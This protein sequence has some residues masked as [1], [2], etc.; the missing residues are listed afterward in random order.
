MLSVPAT[1]NLWNWRRARASYTP[2]SDPYCC[3]LRGQGKTRRGYASQKYYSFQPRESL[4][5]VVGP[6]LGR[7]D[8]KQT[9]TQPVSSHRTLTFKQWLKE[10]TSR[11]SSSLVIVPNEWAT[12]LIGHSAGLWVSTGRNRCAHSGSPLFIYSLSFSL[13]HFSICFSPIPPKNSLFSICWYLSLVFWWPL[14]LCGTLVPESGSH[15]KWSW[16]TGSHHPVKD[17][18]YSKFQTGPFGPCVVAPV[19]PQHTADVFCHKSL[20][21]LTSMQG[22]WPRPLCN[23]YVNKQRQQRDIWSL[24]ITV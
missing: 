5:T 14:G 8:R 24:G 11:Y 4:F 1:P 9:Q 3:F 12:L 13:T 15:W 18:C 21:C 17:H 6:Q 23:A 16:A 19:A 20:R 2:A 22:T 10:I 7:D